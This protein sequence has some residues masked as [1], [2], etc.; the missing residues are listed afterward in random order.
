MHRAMK[1][2]KNVKPTV[3]PSKSHNVAVFINE[4]HYTMTFGGDDGV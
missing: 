3:I 4:N 1:E 2:G